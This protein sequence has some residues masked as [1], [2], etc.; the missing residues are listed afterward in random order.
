[1]FS[2][3]IVVSFCTQ[4]EIENKWHAEVKYWMDQF[5]C[6]EYKITPA[7]KY[8]GREKALDEILCFHFHMKILLQ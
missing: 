1:M 2:F 3:I 5:L 7:L 4:R 6:C 8:S